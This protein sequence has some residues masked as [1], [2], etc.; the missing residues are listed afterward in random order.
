MKETTQ[1]VSF[2]LESQ[3]Y[4]VGLEQVDSIQRMV[5]ISP[6]PETPP[7]MPGVID[8]R[9]VVLPVVD[10]RQRFGHRAR[11]PRLEDR[12][13]VVKSEQRTLVLIVDE[14]NEV[15]E[16]ATS[17]IE[18]SPR[19]LPKSVSAV[20]RREEGLLLILDLDRLVPDDFQV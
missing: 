11:P 20:V 5:A 14:V 6:I 12:L 18:A 9:G 10:L 8:V 13:L 19:L 2:H 16:V 17:S 4:A 3:L 1:L 7:W 15:L